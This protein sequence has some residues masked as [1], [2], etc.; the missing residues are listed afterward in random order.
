LRQHPQG[1]ILFA[2]LLRE[3][4]VRAPHKTTIS[5]QRPARS[6]TFSATSINRDNS[7]AEQCRGDATRAM[8]QVPL[9]APDW[10]RHRAPA[11]REAAGLG[12]FGS[13]SLPRISACEGSRLY[14]VKEL[15]SAQV[16]AL[17]R[18]CAQKD[19]AWRRGSEVD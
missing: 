14:A 17:D 1:P 16:R 10:R 18:S 5:G 2:G 4:V 15:T 13:R 7:V 19:G 12:P 8:P 11:Q 9:S 6:H 3:Q